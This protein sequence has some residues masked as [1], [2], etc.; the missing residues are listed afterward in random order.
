LAQY[1]LEI[2]AIKRADGRSSVAAAAYRS[3][4]KLIDDR[5]M[6]TFD[7]AAKRGVEASGLMAP[8]TAPAAFLER[9]RLWNAAEAADIRSDSRVAREILISLPHE[10]DA[11][12]RL[13]LVRAFVSEVLVAQGMIADYALHLPD[14][15]GDQ[16]NH[17]AH[18]LVTTR[19][20]G[21]AGFG[22]KVRAWDNPD[23]VRAMREAW[24]EIQNRHLRLALGEGAPQVSAKSLADQGLDQE[25]T[26][27]LGP[28]A[29]GMERRG[30]RSD[31]GE[32]NRSVGE[33]NRERRQE[34][35]NL[36]DIEDTL[37]GR[38]PHQD[39]PIGAVAR[40]FEAI[41]HTMKRERDGWARER[42]GF[43]APAIPSAQSIRD[44][45]TAEAARARAVA[46]RRMEATQVRVARVSARRNTLL[47]WVRNPGRMIWAKH[48]ELN[49]LGRERAALARAEV[50][51]SVRRA[52][53]RSPDG[54]RYL[55]AHQHP[56]R[57]AAEAARRADLT[58][59]RKIKR[60]D[61]R[62][63]AIERTRIKLLVAEAL[64]ETR[65]VAPADLSLGVVQAVRE[66]D[67]T[68]VS[69]LARY[70]AAQQARA[71]DLIAVRMGRAPPG[72]DR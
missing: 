28:S 2:Q 72:P 64:G 27:H 66:I 21:P 3:A 63:E 35:Q 22:H 5:L 57:L 26:V 37:S 43:R 19:A 62:I 60:A 30:E 56:Q 16:R 36:R 59:E 31:R 69:A 38:R 33:R 53:L 45:V 9:E 54:Q 61:R 70:P 55:A 11:A 48:A 13:A 52:W 15:H 20:V 51:L 10:L 4:T 6:I 39:Y 65:L 42:A 32:T 47:R 46:R 41:H 58:L 49:A 50:Q 18:I 17:H 23:A 44:A 1:R 71:L 14:L 7:Y 68:V 29:S 8:D 25:A 67:R 24:A 34:R 40:E 12:Q